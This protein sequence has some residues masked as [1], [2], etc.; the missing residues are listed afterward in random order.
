MNIGLTNRGETADFFTG[1]MAATNLGSLNTYIFALFPCLIITKKKKIKVIGLILFSVSVI[2]AFILGTRTTVYA[3]II[4]TAVST[5]IYIKKRYT[6]KIPINRLIKWILIITAIICVAR[7]IYS[8]NS[9]NIRT[10]IESSTLLLR[11]NNIET[12]HSDGIRLK[13]FKEGFA[14]LFEHPLGGNKISGLYYF[15]NYWL[16]VGR[17]AGIVPVI[18]LV[19]LDVMLIRHMLKVFKNKELDE[20]FRF[21]LLGIYM[22]VFFNFFM[23]PIMEGYLDL[24]FR[25]I[26]INGMVEGIYDFGERKK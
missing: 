22:C 5:I 20:D 4:M 26:F 10:N 25:F 9:F 16:D 11:Y 24:F 18:L 17:I 14:Y 21:A 15:H 3:L 8:N 1:H 23:E 12:M 7:L 6:N 19:V 13:Y 2:Y